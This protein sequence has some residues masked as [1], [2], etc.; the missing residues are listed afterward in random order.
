MKCVVRW[1]TAL[2]TFVIQLQQREQ[3]REQCSN[4]QTTEGQYQFDRQSE[5]IID[6]LFQAGS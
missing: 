1:F 4:Y 3:Q 6:R 5:I 2:K